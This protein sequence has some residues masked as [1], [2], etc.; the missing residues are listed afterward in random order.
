MTF[1]PWLSFVNDSI[2]FTLENL[3]KT[4][5]S[6]NNLPC[7][8]SQFTTHLLILTDGDRILKARK[9]K[10]LSIEQKTE[11]TDSASRAIFVNV[12]L[13]RHCSSSCYCLWALLVAHIFDKTS[14]LQSSVED[15]GLTGNED[16]DLL[17]WKNCQ[18]KVL[19]YL[20]KRIILDA[21]DIGKYPSDIQ[22]EKDRKG[23]GWLG[24]P[25]TGRVR[26]KQSR[27][28]ESWLAAIVFVE[29]WEKTKKLVSSWRMSWLKMTLEI[30]GNTIKLF[31]NR[32][33][34]NKGD[35]MCNKASLI[36]CLNRFLLFR[37][38]WST[39]LGGIFD[40]IFHFCISAG[41]S[42]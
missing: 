27:F 41:W 33:L 6:S 3:L 30:T 29:F 16:E 8:V 34:C 35:V 13:F 40:I 12:I 17:S 15:R 5:S 14:F 26:E 10:W 42:T 36:S 37:K 31:C 21:K 11:N 19:S 4:F 28:S 2:C 9:D 18:W 38:T 7:F 23:V 20:G 24:F 1:S 22:R 32:W 39:F 25:S